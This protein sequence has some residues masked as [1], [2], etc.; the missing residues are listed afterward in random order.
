MYTI[1]YGCTTFTS[2]VNCINKYTLSEPNVSKSLYVLL[3]LYLL[4]NIVFME[5]WYV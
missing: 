3:V 4:L 1:Q 5:T 2:R